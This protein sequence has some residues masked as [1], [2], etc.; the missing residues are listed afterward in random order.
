MLASPSKAVVP[1]GAYADR[2]IALGK[3]GDEATGLWQRR[4]ADMIGRQPTTR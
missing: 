3:T 2:P 4:E 1:A